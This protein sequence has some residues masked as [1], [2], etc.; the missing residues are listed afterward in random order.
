MQWIM[1][2][3]DHQA[4]IMALI[5]NHFDEAS[6]RV[7]EVYETY[8]VDT[9]A[10]IGRHWRHKRDIPSDLAAPFKHLWAITS[11]KLLRANKTI[12]FP[13]TGKTQEME[14]IIS[15]Q[16]L[17]L[18][19]LEKKIEDYVRPYQELFERELAAVLEEVPALRRE[20]FSKELE[21]YVG[22]LNT[23]VEGAREAVFFLIMGVVGRVYSDKI[24]FGSS[25]ATG[26]AVAS[27]LYVSQLSWFGSLWASLFGVP[28]WVAWAGM[29][30]GVVVTLAIA[31]ALTPLFEIGI[32]RLRAK[33]ILRNTVDTARH[34]LTGS[35]S[36]AYDV[37]GQT[38]IYLQF[39]PDVIDIARKLATAI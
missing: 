13:K 21:R 20:E 10:V 35:G 32:N 17:D 30:G 22:R 24:T 34:R 26:K 36:D 19:G 27:S 38:A 29:G 18:P 25:L 8:F 7:D 11:R 23:P 39:F 3:Q 37:A 15:E 2:Q 31:P 33:K 1:I 16:L 14:Q 4:A 28:S 5:T 9:R 6:G 12:D